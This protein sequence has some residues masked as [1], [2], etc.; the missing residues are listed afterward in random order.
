MLTE[1]DLSAVQA[2]MLRYIGALIRQ[3]APTFIKRGRT[4][5]DFSGVV[6]GGASC[7]AVVDVELAQR[8]AGEKAVEEA[9]QVFDTPIRLV[10]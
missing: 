7:W 8:L 2:P 6:S 3:P 9:D 4:Y 1:R 5:R 10:P